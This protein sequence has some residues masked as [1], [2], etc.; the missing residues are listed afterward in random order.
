MQ[1]SGL[2]WS[3]SDSVWNKD[4]LDAGVGIKPNIAAGE[5]ME[6]GV[7]LD[8]N[9]LTWSTIAI[10]KVTW[11]Q[12]NGV[13]A[14]TH[15]FSNL[16]CKLKSM[17]PGLTMNM[18]CKDPMPAIRS[19]LLTPYFQDSPYT[20]K[21]LEYMLGKMTPGERLVISSDME[22]CQLFCFLAMMNQPAFKVVIDRGTRG[23]M[24]EIRKMNRYF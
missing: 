21:E 20:A 23:F 5:D 18:T 17:Q 22:K 15:C 16:T 8:V 2:V 12:L 6:K 24:I 1:C 7:T 14:D 4:W 9:L 11:K 19:L 3:W 13:K 10:D